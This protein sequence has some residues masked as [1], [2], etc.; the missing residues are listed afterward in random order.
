M[1]KNPTHFKRINYV[2]VRHHILRDNTEKCHIIMEFCKTKEQIVDIFTKTWN[3]YH[4]KRHR[5]EHGLIKI[6]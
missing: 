4:Y 3:I 1:T 5:L 6:N 2:D